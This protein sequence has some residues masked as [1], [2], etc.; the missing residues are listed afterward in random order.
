MN[1][2]KGTLMRFA[3]R[4]AGENFREGIREHFFKDEL[5]NVRRRKYG[6]I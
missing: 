6:H 3:K 2:F 5:R 4:V 1:T